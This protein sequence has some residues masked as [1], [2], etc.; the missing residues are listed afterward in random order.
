MFE[1]RLEKLS[2]MK[3]APSAAESGALLAS[4]RAG[5]AEGGQEGGE[6]EAMQMFVQRE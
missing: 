1:D 6:E 2:G 3:Q 4:V 5:C